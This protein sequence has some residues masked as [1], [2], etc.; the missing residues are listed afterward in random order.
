MVRIEVVGGGVLKS[1]RDAEPP[2]GFNT[3]CWA[4]VKEAFGASAAVGSNCTGAVRFSDLE[5]A[6]IGF[7]ICAGA[8]LAGLLVVEVIALRDAAGPIG[9]PE[10]RELTT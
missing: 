5:C 4:P 9:T 8:P 7:V 3:S 2:G 6:R 10:G 1:L